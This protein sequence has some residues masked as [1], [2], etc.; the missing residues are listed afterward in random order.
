MS[1]DKT[2]GQPTYEQLKAQYDELE[3]AH[4]GL[5]ASQAELLQSEKLAALGEL[6]ASVAHEL[7]QPLNGIKLICQAILKDIQRDRLDPEELKEDLED[8]VRSVDNM[9][10][11]IDH[12]RR[13]TRGSGPTTITRIDINHPIEQSLK[14]HRQQLSNRSIELELDLAADLPPV[15]GDPLRL[16]EVLVNLINNARSALSNKADG[17]KKLRLASSAHGDGSQVLIE[18][19]D[20]GEGI[21]P[22]ITDKIFEPFFTTREPGRGTGLGLSV[23]RKIIQEHHGKIDVQSEPG[24]GAT[25]R[26]VLPVAA[27]S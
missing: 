12:M 11:T 7:N 4:Q 9:A 8:A 27:S 1:G 13:F 19:S 14:L 17:L 3:R 15:T 22:N 16:E 18:I 2:A 24:Q 25:F 20:T 23:A 10:E 21:A 26:I 6:S 5:K